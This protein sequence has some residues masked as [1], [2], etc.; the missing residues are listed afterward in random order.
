ME[1]YRTGSRCVRAVI[2]RGCAY[3][4]MVCRRIANRTTGD[5]LQSSSNG[6][7]PTLRRPVAG[8]HRTAL[9]RACRLFRS[10]CCCSR[11][12]LSIGPQR[13]LFQQAWCDS[14]KLLPACRDPAGGQCAGERQCDAE[15]PAFRCGYW[16]PARAACRANDRCARR[17]ICC[18][19]SCP[20]AETDESDRQACSAW[21]TEDHSGKDAAGA[22]NDRTTAAGETV[23]RF[24]TAGKSRRS[25]CRSGPGG[26]SAVAPD[27]S[28]R[29]AAAARCLEQAV[30]RRA[31]HAA[32]SA[33][34]RAAKLLT[35]NPCTTKPCT[36]KPC[37][38]ARCRAYA[39]DG[40]FVADRQ[41]AA[42]IHH[43][44]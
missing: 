22:R 21:R 2:G 4:R 39:R 20:V 25:E 7:S 42:A 31:D 36:A 26:A 38:T 37:T 27:G 24:W 18:R 17:S 14:E 19:R 32:G 12:R 28:G 35:T 15:R 10:R 13:R 30:A 29:L 9:A 5:R 8:C 23:P 40:R 1:P 3:R 11:R 33:A 34:G 6:I 16:P 44:R 43:G 41:G